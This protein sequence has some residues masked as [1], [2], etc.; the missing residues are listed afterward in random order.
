MYICRHC[1]GSTRNDNIR[2]C[3]NRNCAFYG[4][5]AKG[6]NGIPE[7]S[8]NEPQIFFRPEE[9]SK[10]SGGI[11]HDS[12]LHRLNDS[13]YSG[14]SSHNEHISG[15]N[16]HSQHIAPVSDYGRGARCDVP[17]STHS[18]GFA[19]VPMQQF[20]KIYSPQE[21]MKTGTLFPALDMPYSQK[22][23]NRG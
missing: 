20:G 3:N 13:V 4:H 11:F 22:I 23:I 18:Y 8:S 2:Y 21:A 9:V 5:T 17:D 19:T 10:L 16:M 14:I 12:N 6:G 15:I 7:M 1:G